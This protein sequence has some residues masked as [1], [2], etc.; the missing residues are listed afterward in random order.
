MSDYLLFVYIINF[1]FLT[2]HEMD[3][4]YWREW[5]MLGPLKKIGYSGYLAI[6]IPLM[7][8][9]LY[10]LLFLQNGTTFG[11]IASYCLA[12]FGLFAYF[13]HFYHLRISKEKFD[14][15]ISKMI[16]YAILAA[17]IIQLL[18]TSFIIFWIKQ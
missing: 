18:L 2:I 5:E 7:L 17:S 11:M 13:F 15:L 8:F 10:A 16:L 6:H 4:A 14:T 12:F 1:T 9:F 3:S